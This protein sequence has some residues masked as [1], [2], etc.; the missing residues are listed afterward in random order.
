VAVIDKAAILGV[1]VGSWSI[2]HAS[3]AMIRTLKNPKIFLDLF[4][5]TP[6]FNKIVLVSGEIKSLCLWS[7]GLGD[8]TD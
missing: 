3:W 5:T 7:R 8:Q 6:G 2:A 4:I 1:G